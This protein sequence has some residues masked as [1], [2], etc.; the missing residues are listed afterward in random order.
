MTFIVPTWVLF[1]GSSSPNLIFIALTEK[2]LQVYIWNCPPSWYA[3]YDHL[4]QS[5]DRQSHILG[6]N[7]QSAG[8]FRSV[9]LVYST[10]SV[11]KQM[12]TGSRTIILR[13]FYLCSNQR[14]SFFFKIWIG[15]LLII[16][17]N[18]NKNGPES[19]YS[20]QTS[21]SFFCKFEH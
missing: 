3:I 18:N 11:V 16:L 4:S 17:F 7:K 8:I 13:I 1:L 20:T 9:P 14:F 5:F 21:C 15:I 12:F 10:Y 19:R 6:N 2:I